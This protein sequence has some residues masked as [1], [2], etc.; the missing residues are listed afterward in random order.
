[1][2]YLTKDD[3]SLRISVTNLDEILAEAAES[4]GLS[5]DNCRTNA[6][7]WATATLKSYLKVKYDVDAELAIIVPANRNY[8]V[9]QIL[10]D[11]S[12]CTL[13]KTISPRNV[14]EHISLSCEKAVQWL[15]DA[16]DNKIVVEL[17][18]KLDGEG[19]PETEYN[20]FIQ[21]QQKFI[22]KPYQDLSIL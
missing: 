13:T 19:T 21:S 2:A 8:Q 22:S 9:L 6:E 16:R 5:A 10:I 4:S 20:T 15:E 1:M 7:A 18:P 12:L 17:S 14:P 11:L 3:Y